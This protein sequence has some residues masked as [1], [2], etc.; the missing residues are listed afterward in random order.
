[1]AAIGIV[2]PRSA[3]ATFPSAS[4][5]AMMPEPTTVTT[6]SPEPITSAASVR[7]RGEVVRVD[8]ER[9]WVSGPGIADGLEGSSPPEPLQVLGE[10]VGCDECQHVSL[11]AVQ[12]RIVEHLDGGVFHGSVHPLSLAVGPRVIGLG[13]PVLDAVLSADP[14]ED[15]GAQPSTGRPVSVLR[16]IGE[17]HAVVGQD[18][19]DRIRDSSDHLPQ[20]GRSV[21]L[22]GGIE[23]GDV[24][25]CADPIDSQEHVE[26]AFGQAQLA[27]VDVHVADPGLSKPASLGRA[28]TVFGQ[29]RDAVAHEAAVERAAG[30][31]GDALTQAAEHVIQ[32]SSK[33]SRVRRR[34]STTMASSASVRTVLRGR[35]GP[36]G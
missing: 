1:M 35:T 9:R 2:L 11:E 18:G 3:T 13:E 15:G 6:R 27:V 4:F 28:L 29:P 32:G 33:G 36:I 21:H 10:V 19:V 25:E 16:Q 22:C 34:N 12:V 5:S 26:L 24:G 7:S 30:Q 14:V 23:E 17:R 31:L 20:E 8:F